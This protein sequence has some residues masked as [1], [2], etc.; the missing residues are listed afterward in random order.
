[1]SLME[2]LQEAKSD[3]NVVFTAVEQLT[4]PTEMK[5][6][7]QEYVAHLRQNGDSAEVRA[8]PESVANSNI[9]YIVGY[10][11]KE[12]ADRWMNTIPSVSHPIFGKNVFSVA[13]EDAFKA[14]QL[15]ATEGT[16]KARQYIEGKK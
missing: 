3:R 12:T 14:G 16:E 1:M 13:P 8:N 7:Y 4:D 15:A 9:G 6:F 11:D 10:Y 5:Q 2:K